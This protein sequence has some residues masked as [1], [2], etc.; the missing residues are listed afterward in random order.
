[1]PQNSATFKQKIALFVRKF[2]VS[3]FVIFSFAAYVIHERTTNV[4]TRS[5]TVPFT[6]II[7][8]TSPANSNAGQPPVVVITQVPSSSVNNIRQSPAATRTAPA[9][10]TPKPAAIAGSQYH[11]GTY[12]GSLANAHFGWVQVQTTIQN[13]QIANVQF[14]QYPSDRRT[15]QRINQYAA[16][17]LT[18]E[19]IQAQSANVNIISGATLTSRAFTESLQSAL[20]NA[21]A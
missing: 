4:G 14:L 1:M 20:S 3:A 9:T 2:C 15:S 18:Q 8:P 6:G 17:L 21:K 11:D 19:A 13:G 10:V 7:S 12:T 16:P 5:D